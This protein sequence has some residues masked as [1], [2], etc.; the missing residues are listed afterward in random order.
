M[1]VSTT[2]SDNTKYK[3]KIW[4]V[5]NNAW[6]QFKVIS[7][8]NGIQITW[9]KSSFEE[10]NTYNVFKGKYGDDSIVFKNNVLKINDEVIKAPTKLTIETLHDFLS[11]YYGTLLYF[12]I[13]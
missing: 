11:I 12:E 3:L 4:E 9:S 5:W 7:Y 1:K 6:T 2:K 8:E 10:S 13:K